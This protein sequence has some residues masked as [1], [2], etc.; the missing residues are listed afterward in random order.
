MTCLTVGE[1]VALSIGLCG[2][3]TILMKNQDWPFR[4]HVRK[5]GC[6]SSSDAFCTRFTWC[7]DGWNLPFYVWKSLS[8]YGKAYEKKSSLVATV[9][10][11]KLHL[12]WEEMM[13]GAGKQ[14]SL[15]CCSQS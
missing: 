11:V 3:E 14:F 8:S 15:T 6:G 4:L 1:S 10:M 9:K 13:D 2:K 7:I 12:L 5:C